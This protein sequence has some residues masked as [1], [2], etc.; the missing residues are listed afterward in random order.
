VC[1]S[2]IK[3]SETEKLLGL[4]IS[5][6]LSW[7]EHVNQITSTKNVSAVITKKIVIKKA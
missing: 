3:E 1:G 6:D 5:K 4:Y 2:D 7:D